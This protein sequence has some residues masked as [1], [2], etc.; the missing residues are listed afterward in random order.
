MIKAGLRLKK[1]K[2]IKILFRL[3]D[4]YG[5][6]YGK[7]F[8]KFLKKTGGKIDYKLLSSAVVAYRKTQ[9]GF[10]VAYSNINKM[11]SELKRRGY[12]LAIL[13]DAPRFNAWIRLTELG[14]VDYFDVVITLG[15]VKYK[16]PHKIP[17]RAV[18][19]KLKLK[20]Q[21]ALM[22]GDNIKRDI[23]GARRLGIKTVL[24]KYGCL[25]EYEK[26]ADFEIN[27]IG[28]LMDIVKRLE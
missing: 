1:K 4:E 9:T 14:I 3:Y 2:A 18:L 10:L 27:R 19:R 24:A 11:L 8:Q 22:V 23:E 17:F 26:K 5:I 15:D 6:E 7:I 12:K 25:G 28:D 16:K 21:E 13:S 20:P